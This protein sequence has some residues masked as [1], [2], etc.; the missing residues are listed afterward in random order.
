MEKITQWFCIFV[1]VPYGNKV[2][3]LL[4][5]IQKN[6]FKTKLGELNQYRYIIDGLQHLQKSN[7][8]LVNQFKIIMEI[9][10]ILRG[11]VLLNGIKFE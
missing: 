10:K 4:E 1:E 8:T 11:S 2:N 7:E 5:V 6:A 3:K 9:K